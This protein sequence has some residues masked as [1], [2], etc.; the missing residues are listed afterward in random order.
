MS[1]PAA[2]LG[3]MTAHGGAIVVGFPTV[4]VGGMPAARLA[5][6][7]VCPMVT[8][9]VPHVGGPIALGST[10]VL[11]GNMPAARVGDMVT[12]VGPPDVI[13]MGCPTVLI[14]EIGSGSAS[15]GGA[16]GGAGNGASASAA[17]AMFDN[18]ESTTKLEHWVEFKFLDK[19][20]LPVSGI[21]Y[22]FTDPD[23]KEAN[24]VLQLDGRLTRDAV[25][26]GQSSVILQ[27]IKDVKW[28]KDMAKVGD[29]LT[30]TA[31]LE[32]FEDGDQALVQIFK[33]DLR[34]P[35]VL[36]EERAEKVQG[37]KIETSWTYEL[38]EADEDVDVSGSENDVK[39]TANFSAPEFYFEVLAG[40]SK[41]RSG[42]LALE[43][44]IE[45]ELKDEDGKALAD[46]DY[47]LYLPN[48]EVRT[49]KLDGGGK[50]KEEKIPAGFCQ[51]RFP[52][53]PDYKP[54]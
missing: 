53:L 4:L 34:G 22:K 1:K 7:H 10:G 41:G 17:V 23:G 52:T 2:R 18:N 33:R 40:L 14:G 19:A 50:V 25:N 36:V 5:D 24:G 26:E 29:E 45:I 16:G 9:L 49:G 11:I 15:G 27:G 8:G 54:E 39:S 46:L 47:I 44:F 38:P 37:G 31:K 32:G 35:D 48:G 42:L 21:P 28:S 20:G 30:L 13:A 51:V 3:D 6:M 43:D 12:C